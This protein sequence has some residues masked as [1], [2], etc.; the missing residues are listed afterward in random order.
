MKGTRT[1]SYRRI[2]GNGT[3]GKTNRPFPATAAQ[4]VKTE[5]PA[6]NPNTFADTPRVSVK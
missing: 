5:I 2:A 1:S 4:R 3:H 6:N